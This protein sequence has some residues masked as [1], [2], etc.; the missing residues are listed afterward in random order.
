MAQGSSWRRRR[1]SAALGMVMALPAAV[2]LFV[3]LLWPIVVSA[4][5]SGT[6]ATGYGDMDPVGLD[7]YRR[8]FSDQSFYAAFGRNVIFALVVVAFTVA[9]GFLLAYVLFLRVR[10]WRGLQVLFMIPYIM[11]VVVTA[12]LWKFML[13]PENGLVNNTLRRIGLSWL[14]GPNLTGESTALGTVS[15][16][17]VWVLVPFAMLL[18]FGAMI[19][20]PNDVIEAA[21]LDGAN[22]FV[23]MF[24][25]VLPMVGPTVVLVGFVIAVQLFRSFDLVFLLTQGGPVGSTTISTL[26]VFIQGFTNNEYGYANALGVVLGTVLVLLALIPQVLMRRR[27]RVQARVLAKIEETVG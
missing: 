13:E 27:A 20:L 2:L 23:K 1:G 15:L 10:G 26:Y 3:F 4:Q 9:I 21:D 11:P 17:Q 22:H 14:A 5:Y 6:S 25:V 16:V 24:R 18:I 12:L 8:V 7:N 19:A